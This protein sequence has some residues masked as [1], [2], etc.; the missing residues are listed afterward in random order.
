MRVREHDRPRVNPL[1][2]PQPIEAAIDHYVCTA[3]RDQ[4]RGV[5]PVPSRARLDF[6]ARAEKRQVH[7]G[8]ASR[9]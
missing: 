2:F 6:A 4:Q 1:K 8:H 7:R 9:F 5:H 3:V